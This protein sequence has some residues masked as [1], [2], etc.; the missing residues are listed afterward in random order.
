MR[1]VFINVSQIEKDDPENAHRNSSIRQG[2][3]VDHEGVFFFYPQASEL[4]WGATEN[5]E[6][7]TAN[8]AIFFY[9]Y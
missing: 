3:Y 6:S 5:N 9:S 8:K 2:G 1:F 4:C 7:I